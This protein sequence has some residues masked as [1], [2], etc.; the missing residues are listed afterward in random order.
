MNPKKTI[1][2]N[3]SPR[4][5][6]TSVLT[7]TLQDDKLS[8]KAGWVLMLL[9]SM[10]PDWDVC[11]AWI[12]KRR[13]LGRDTTRN[14]MR[15]LE[16]RGFIR[17]T[18]ERKKDGTAGRY[19]Y[20]VTDKPHCF[21]EGFAQAPAVMPSNRAVRPQD[22]RRKRRPEPENQFPAD[23]QNQGLP[24]PDLPAPD[25]RA[26][27]KGQTPTK[28]EVSRQK[29]PNNPP[30]QSKALD[31]LPSSLG[32]T[33]KTDDQAGSAE[34]LIPFGDDDGEDLARHSA[35]WKARDAAGIDPRAH[36]PGN[37]SAFRA[38]CHMLCVD[39]V[40][41]LQRFVEKGGP[42]KA[43]RPT[44]YLITMAQEVAA[45]R[46]GISVAEVAE[47]FEAQKASKAG[48]ALPVTAGDLEALRN[49]RAQASPELRA[50]IA[51]LRGLQ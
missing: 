8:A 10:P 46:D 36:I 5:P 11:L 18:Q 34:D 24:E 26:P 15:E 39:P 19:C 17:L 50:S 45:E 22:G 43:K 3:A 4:D 6:Y 21:G 14:V 51:R 1:F 16:T 49:K 41:V 7:A 37:T 12:A 33:D 27:T 48:R 25:S 44:A 35:E 20:L 9:L 2:R 40:P 23:Q 38:A 28:E 42:R 29:D 13:R 31:G 32:S 47:A 30:K